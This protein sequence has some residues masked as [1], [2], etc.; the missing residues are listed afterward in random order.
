MDEDKERKMKLPPAIRNK[1]Y[2]GQRL[3]SDNELLRHLFWSDLLEPV[4][5]PHLNSLGFSPTELCLVSDNI[6]AIWERQ[7]GAIN[8]RVLLPLSLREKQGIVEIARQFLESQGPYD[9]WGP[10]LKLNEDCSGTKSF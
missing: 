6:V 7:D 2:P 4:I 8:V 3:A 10:A 9:N 1:R 5:R